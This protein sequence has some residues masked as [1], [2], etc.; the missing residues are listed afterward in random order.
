MRYFLSSYLNVILY[1]Y[2]YVLG[3]SLLIMFDGDR[4]PVL[5]VVG[6]GVMYVVVHAC[7]VGRQHMKGVR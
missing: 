7:Y 1:A 5:Y 2:L 3:V 4:M 6:V